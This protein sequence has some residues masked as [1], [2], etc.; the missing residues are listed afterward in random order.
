MSVAEILNGES[1]NVEYKARVP[2]K[3]LNYMKTVVAFA[4]GFGGRLVLG[5]AGTTRP[6]DRYMVREL[7]FEGSNRSFDQAICSELTVSEDDIDALCRAMQEEARRNARSDEQRAAIKNVG[8]GQLLSWGILAEKDGVALATNAYAILTGNAAVPPAMIQCGV[9]K[10]KTRA[11]FVDRREY[12]GPIWEQIEQAYQ[13]VLRNIHLGAEFDGLYRQDVYEIPPEA[14]REL[15]INAAVHRSYLDHGAIQVAIY[16]DRLEVTS[17]GK[18][19]M[20]QTLERMQ[21]GYSKIRNE[22]LAYAFSYMNLIEHWGSGIPRVTSQVMAAGLRAPEFIGGDVDLRINVYRRKIGVVLAENDTLESAD[23]TLAVKN[24]TLALGND[25][26]ESADD[27]LASENDEALET[28]LLAM[29]REDPHLTQQQLAERLNV[30]VITVKRLMTH[31]QE[32]AQIKRDGS[33]RYGQWIILRE[34]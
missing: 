23:D 17:P 31:L 6:A 8:R 19:P 3:S 14:I 1:V 11:V 22:A 18:L 5:V 15:I 21:E 2:E 24:D 27:T 10:G 7:L 28:K 34:K 9:F 29:I 30:S 26:L 4:N 32:H 12:G 20:G 25:T 33:K 16:D 13:F